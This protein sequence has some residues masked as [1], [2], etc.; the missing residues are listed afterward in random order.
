MS[1]VKHILESLGYK[2][3]RDG[4]GWRARPIYRTS[5]NPTSLQ[6]YS[7]GNFVDY[8]AGIQGT[9]PELIALTLNKTTPQA[10]DWL[11]T[12]NFE[13]KP[14]TP[15]PKIELPIKWKKDILNTFLD[16]QSY[17]ESRG[18]SAQTGHLFKGGLVKEDKMGGRYVIPIFDNHDYIVGLVGRDISHQQ[19]LKYKILGAKSHFVWGGHL[20]NPEEK[21][22]ILVESPMCVLKLYEAG[23]KGTLCLWGIKALDAIVCYL[24]SIQ[25]DNIIIS[26]NKDGEENNRI[27]EKA[28]LR[29]KEK[30]SYFF[31]EKQIEH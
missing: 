27:G 19:K 26:L 9:F 18:I 30:L 16:D 11:K 29:V 2:L 17:I 8:S 20:L 10:Y 24:T 12:K 7:N 3:R 13:Y 14:D 15:L 25:P 23:I 5:D 31:N 1:E 21:T 22:I 4:K 6:I 28:S